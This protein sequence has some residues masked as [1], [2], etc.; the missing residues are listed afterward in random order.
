MVMGPWWIKHW[1]RISRG[2]LKGYTTSTR[3]ATKFPFA[4]ILKS[5]TRCHRQM[6]LSTASD[7]YLLGTS[8]SPTSLMSIIPC[9]LPQGVSPAI[10]GVKTKILLLNASNDRETTDFTSATD[11][12]SAIVNA[13]SPDAIWTE[14]VTHVVYLRDG[15]VPVHTEELR[16]RGVE[17]VGVMS[18]G[19]MGRGYDI[20]VLEKVLA[21]ICGGHTGLNR[22]ATMQY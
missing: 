7:R 6:Y 3:T 18:T 14:Y 16:Q 1:R 11:Y 4:R 15:A 9:L 10:R 19:G 21:G 2:R 22:R 17:C 12:I 8:L 20:G 5:L 13:C